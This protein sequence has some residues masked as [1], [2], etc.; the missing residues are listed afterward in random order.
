[1]TRVILEIETDIF[2]RRGSITI[3]ELALKIRRKEFARNRH[4]DET[5]SF[6]W[7]KDVIRFIGDECAI[8]R[9]CKTRPIDTARRR[10]HL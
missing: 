10:C 4:F 6:K 9:V 7:L 1:L 8:G 2:T 3:I 5:F